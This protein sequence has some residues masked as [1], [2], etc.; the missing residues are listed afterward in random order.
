MRIYWGTRLLE[1]CGD[2]KGKVWKPGF[3]RGPQRDVCDDDSGNWKDELLA[4]YREYYESVNTH[5]TIDLGADRRITELE[6]ETWA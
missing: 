6:K 1:K 2:M 3:E 4:A 5:G